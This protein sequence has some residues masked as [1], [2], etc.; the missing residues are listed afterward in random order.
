MKDIKKFAIVLIVLGL[1]MLVTHWLLMKK[2]EKEK[3]EKFI[4]VDKE[5]FWLELYQPTA[6]IDSSFKNQ[7]YDWDNYMPGKLSK[8]NLK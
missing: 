5:K 7:V 2:K 4:V 8:T 1:P 6:R 3:M